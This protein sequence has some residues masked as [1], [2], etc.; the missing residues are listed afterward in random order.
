M[1]KADADFLQII[2]NADF[3]PVMRWVVGVPTTLFVDKEGNIVGD[4]IVGA[5]VEGYKQFVED[6]FG[7]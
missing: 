4:P 5:D 2:A 7:E 3:G 6:Y 1:E